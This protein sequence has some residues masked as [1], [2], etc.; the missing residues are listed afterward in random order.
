MSFKQEKILTAVLYQAQHKAF[1]EYFNE[2]VRDTHPMRP[3]FDQN[4]VPRVSR[5]PI[6]YKHRRETDKFFELSPS[7]RKQ[8]PACIQHRIPAKHSAKVRVTYDQSTRGVI[9]KIIKARVADLDLHMPRCPFDCRIS[10]NLEMDWDGTVEE[11]EREAT[12]QETSP[13]RKKDRLSYTQSHYQ[14]DLTQVTHT[15]T[16]LHVSVS[17]HPVC[18]YI[19]TNMNP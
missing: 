9:A 13:D 2:L 12:V 17:D 8:L 15:V 16:G 3:A 7:L 14:I 5:V 19:A 1:N 4:G 6:M 18:P 11:L 10:V